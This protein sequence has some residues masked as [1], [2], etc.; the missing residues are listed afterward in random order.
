NLMVS[1]Q[2]DKGMFRITVSGT[3]K[4]PK[5]AVEEMVM[6]I[7]GAQGLVW[8]FDHLYV[9]L[10]GK[11]L[12]RM[13]DSNNDK[14]FDILEYLGG[15]KRRG[16]HGNHAVVKAPNSEDLY[17]INGNHTPP[18]DFTASTLSGWEEDILLPRQ[19]D[20]QGHARGITAPGGTISRISPDASEWE[21]ISI[22]YRNTFDAA[23]NK[24]GEVF[25]Y[26]SD[27]EWDMG[28]PW[29]RPTRL[30]H[31]VSGSDNGWR[32]GSGKFP[33]YYEDTTPP[34]LNIGPGSPTGLTFGYGADFPARYQ[35][36]L[37]GLDWTFGT[38]YAFHLTPNGA[39]YSAEAEVFLSG[40]PL[41]MT[42]AVIGSDGALYFITG[43]RDL[44][45]KLYRVVYT[46]DKSTEPA[47]GGDDYP[48]A[49]EARE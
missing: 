13:R 23:V 17:V 35:Q 37:F 19:W 22:G 7:S 28:M 44:E 4:E 36:A 32:A 31:V 10:N 9:N 2:K 41:P 21:I 34:I 6:P 3:K 12:F 25:T 26:D 29:Y 42:D 30:V 18:P 20:A 43:G 5:V 45:S 40:S 15:P 27:M 47:E 8:A 49:R 14:Q 46:G 33:S 11:G 38:M 24:Q 39:S 48:E 1:N 16:E